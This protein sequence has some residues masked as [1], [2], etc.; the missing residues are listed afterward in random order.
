M[1]GHVHNRKRRL[2]IQQSLFEVSFFLE[3]ILAI[4]VICLVVM[5]IASLMLL[6]KDHL[7]D[8]AITIE[9]SYFLERAMDIVLSIEFLK[10]LCRHNLDSV[11]EVLSFAMARHMIVHASTMVEGLICAAGIAILFIVRKYLFIEKIDKIP[12]LDEEDS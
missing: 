2:R 12:N 4:M 5:E 1:Q 6:F 9:Y 10:M 11:V 8:P 7:L 3:F